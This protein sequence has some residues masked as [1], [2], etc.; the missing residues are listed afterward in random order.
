MR[1]S[2]G[3]QPPSLKSSC[4]CITQPRK[5]NNSQS[6]LHPT[7]NGWQTPVIASSQ[8]QPQNRIPPPRR[9]TTTHVTSRRGQGEPPDPLV[10]VQATPP[11]RPTTAAGNPSRHQPTFI[12]SHPL[13]SSAGLST[14]HS[15]LHAA[16][17][18]LST[19]TS[20]PPL[21]HLHL[22]R[23]ARSYSCCPISSASQPNTHVGSTQ[24]SMPCYSSLGRYTPSATYI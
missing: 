18:L 15:S 17:L 16:Q 19:P 13:A 12:V 23:R 3:V 21:T 9:Q 20:L 24:S 7:S 11:T 1:P 14:H 4:I 22:G 5:L 10:Q 8:A 2:K 6:L